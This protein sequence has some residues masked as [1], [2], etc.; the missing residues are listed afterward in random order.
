MAKLAVGKK[1]PNFKG[2]LEDGSE[3]SS[4][5]L[6]GRKYVLYFYPA[7]DTPT[8]TK[9]SCNLRDNYSLLQAA[10]YEVYGVSPDGLK[11]HVKF[12]NKYDLPFSLIA[13]EEKTICNL[14]GV[15]GEKTNFGRTYMGV[16]RTTFVIDDKGMIE[17]IIEKVKAGEH[18]NQVLGN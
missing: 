1:T 11:S 6:L 17:Q 12:I 8:C 10:G 4:K 16:K 9:Q 15:W 3:I 13:D 5:A 18:S 7:D 14:F 2:V